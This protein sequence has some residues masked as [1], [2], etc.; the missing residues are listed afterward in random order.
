MDHTLLGTL[1]VFGGNEDRLVVFICVTVEHEG[2]DTQAREYGYALG[3]L[4]TQEGPD[5]GVAGGGPSVNVAWVIS[6][7]EAGSM[8]RVS[9][10]EATGSSLKR[11]C[12]EAAE[13]E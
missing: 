4:S 11:D 5:W 13:T 6:L 3:K 12:H 8:E 10:S 1:F 2:V 9:T 7:T